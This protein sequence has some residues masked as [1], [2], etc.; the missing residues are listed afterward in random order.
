MYT[1]SARERTGTDE[2]AVGAAAPSA[3]SCRAGPTRWGRPALP[4]VELRDLVR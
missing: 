1:R 3:D 4:A 2:A